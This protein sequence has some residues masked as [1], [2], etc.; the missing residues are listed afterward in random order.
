MI[1]IDNFIDGAHHAPASNAYLPVVEPATGRPYARVAESNA[2]DVERAVAAAARAKRSWA[3][4]PAAERSAIMMRIADLIEAEHDALAQ[5]ESKDTGKPVSLASR[6][7]IP[8]AAANFRFFATAILHTNSELHQS[9]TTAL[10]LTLRQPRGIAGLISPWNLPLYLFSW[11]VAPAIATGNVAIGKPSEVTP[12]TAHLLGQLCIKAG[13]PPGVLNIVHGSGAN[14]GAAIVAHPAVTTIS[15]TGGTAT[16]AAIASVAAP[17]FK[18]LSLELGGKNPTIVM[19]DADIERAVDET[20]RAAFTNQGQV[21]LCGSR[22]FIASTI[23]STFVEKLVAKV[24]SLRVG[25]PN[26]PV[27]QGALVSQQQLEKVSSFVEIARREGGQIL[28]GGRRP[29]NL[30]PRCADGFFYQPTLIADLSADSVVNTDEI[31]GPVATLQRFDSVDEVVEAA[32]C[33]RYGLSASIWTNNLD[34]ALELAHRIDAGTVWI[35]SWLLRDLRVPFGGTKDS[36]VGREGGD[37]AL[38]FFSEPKNVCIALPTTKV[39]EQR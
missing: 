15:F 1:T 13:L 19:E 10:N 17:K 25:D 4:T 22:I 30:P 21:C 26:D 9:D 33:V 14:V 39:A 23:Y 6:I 24:E 20:C 3:Q 35:N 7:D 27:D 31:F 5:A 16:G 32:N 8:R 11:K 38:R 12:M 18:K 37:E 36:G 28:T 2:Q 34:S 29:A